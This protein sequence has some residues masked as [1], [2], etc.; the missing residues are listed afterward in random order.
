MRAGSPERRLNENH[1][2]GKQPALG[3]QVHRR[4]DRPAPH[5][6]IE[7]ARPVVVKRPVRSVLHRA[8]SHPVRLSKYALA[9]NTA[10]NVAANR[11]RLAAGRLGRTG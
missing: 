3:A 8:G 11:F 4:A 1:P 2:S 9:V 6:G 5:V 10:H 7:R